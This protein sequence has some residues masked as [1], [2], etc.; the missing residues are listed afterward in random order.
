VYANREVI[1]SGGAVNSPRLLLLSGIGP[2]DELRALGI[3]VVHDLPGVGKNLQDHMDVYLTAQTTP[4]SYNESDRPIKALLAGLQ[5][6]TTRT[7]PATASVC[8]AGMFVRSSQDV[9]TPDI[10]MHALP[11]FVIDH[12]RMRVRGH[13][14]TINTC[15]IRPRSVGQITLRSADPTVEPAIDPNFLADPYDW[16]ISMAGFRWG[17]EMLASQAFAPFVTREHMP[18]KDIRSDREI[19]DYIRQWAKTDYHPVGSC[20]MGSDNLAVVD[21]RLRVHGLAGLRVVDASIMPILISGNTQATSVMIGEKGAQHLLEDN[22]ADAGD[23][24]SRS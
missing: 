5:Y 19:S 1:L 17:R 11:A 2:A 3:D 23:P 10:Q 15:N 4:V 22:G 21:Q 16:K 8:E 9:E 24:A 20:K 18:G 14:M 7:G 12:G 13:G 6:V